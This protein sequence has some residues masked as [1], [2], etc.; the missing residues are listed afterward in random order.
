MPTETLSSVITGC[1]GNVTTCSRMSVSG[2]TRSTSGKTM[3]SPGRSVGL[4]PPQRSTTPA[5][6][7]GITR[8]VF[9]ARNTANTNSTASTIRPTI[10]SSL[11]LGHERRRAA[12]LHDVPPRA[13]VDD[14]VVV[15][16]SR[17]PDLAVEPHAADALVVRDPL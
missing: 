15:V 2:R 13:G 8:T 7:C 17:R 10:G 11:L 6:A 4:Y 12:D 16:A 3:C 9:A 1:G 5:R 14:L